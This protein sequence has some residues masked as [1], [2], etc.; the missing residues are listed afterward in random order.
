MGNISNSIPDKLGKYT[1]AG[2]L[3][4]GSMATVYL[5]NDPFIS[6]DVAIKVALPKYLK[7]QE[8]TTFGVDYCVR[9]KASIDQIIQCSVGMYLSLPDRIRRCPHHD[10]SPHR[11]PLLSEARFAGP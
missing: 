9:Q 3:G 1:L 6:R 2:E 11:H 7:D 5:A 8:N 10:P 4:H